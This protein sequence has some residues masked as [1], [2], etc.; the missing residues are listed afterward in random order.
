MQRR[1]IKLEK[2]GWKAKAL[3]GWSTLEKRRLKEDFPAHY[4]FLWRGNGEGG[5][6]LPGTQ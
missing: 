6:D 3:I 2:Q 4:S 1:A 5:A